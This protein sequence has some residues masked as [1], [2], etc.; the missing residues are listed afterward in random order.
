MIKTRQPIQ[1]IKIHEGSVAEHA[2]DQSIS[3]GDILQIWIMSY[4]TWI[5]LSVGVHVIFLLIFSVVALS[6]EITRD[7]DV[8][9]ILRNHDI[10]E[11]LKLDEPRPVFEPQDLKTDDPADDDFTHLVNDPMD[12][13]PPSQNDTLSRYDIADK[14]IDDAI[15]TGP[16]AGPRGGPN[17]RMKDR[18]D[19]DKH[20]N[21]PDKTVM[22]GLLWL[23][24]HQN[25]NGSWGAT[26]FQH[27]CQGTKCGGTGSAKYDVGITG[28]ALLA[29]TGAGYT[30]E[31]KETFGNDNICFGYVVRQAAL[32]LISIQDDEGV[33]GSVT[34]GKFMYNQ[35]VATYALTD[36]YG[37]TAHTAAGVMV[38]RDAQKAVDYLVKAQNP[39]RAWRYQPRDGDNDVSV[40]GWCA[41]ALKAAEGA[42]LKVPHAA[43]RDMKGYLDE[44]TDD[45]YG[46]VGYVTKGGRAIRQKEQNINVA[47]QDALT[48]VGV[49]T[50]IFIDGDTR[51]ERIKKGANLLIKSLPDWNTDDYGKLDYYYWFYASYALYQYDGPNGY[52]WNAW[53]KNMKEV[54]MAHQNNLE[55]TCQYGSWDTAG[56]W[57]DEAGRVYATAINV[58]TLEVYYRLGIVTRT[59]R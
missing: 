25:P 14:G 35:A 26:S 51:D 2:L 55:G 9:V 52:Y 12:D 40:M 31:S 57:C 11:R 41:M 49:M 19:E 54:L 4:G 30:S 58:L 38:K 59:S 37:L 43:F 13:L 48:A 6:G 28:L 33:F 39:G 47:Y 7:N 53:N 5:G 29:F 17:R 42:G 15:G 32:F 10:P 45:V 20:G 34:P 44:V 21:P 46:T 16:G 24:R 18:L 56:R 3:F 22:A 27:Q 8:V 1:E 36:L 23:A 50:R